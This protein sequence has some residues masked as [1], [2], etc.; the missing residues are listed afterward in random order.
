[1]TNFLQ[2]SNK[3]SSK[4]RK[5]INKSKRKASIGEF[6]LRKAIINSLES[7]NKKELPVPILITKISEPKAKDIDI[8]MI[9]ADAYH[10]ACR[11]KKNQVFAVSMR[12]IQYQ[13]EKEARAK[14]N[15]K[16]IVSQEYYNFLDVFS[17]KNSDTLPLYLKYDHK[18]H[19]KEEWKP[20]YT[21]LYKMSSEKIYAVK[22]YLDS[23]LAK[24]FI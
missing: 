16:S 4:K 15:P 24:R 8:A 5:Q 14:T 2:T 20:G 18:I 21:L 12:D 7:S 3:L 11:L 23:Y 13:A 6:S 17:K 22:R 19:L 9:D 10:A 1:M